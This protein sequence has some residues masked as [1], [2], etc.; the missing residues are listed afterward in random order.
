[1][2]LTPHNAAYQRLKESISQSYP[3][4]WFVAIAEDRIIAAS[5]NFRELKGLVQ[6]EGFDPRN[7]LIVEAGVSYPDF[8]DVFLD[9]LDR[10]DELHFAPSL[11]DKGR[12][13]H[14]RE[15]NCLQNPQQ[16]GLRFWREEM[17]EHGADDA[18]DLKSRSF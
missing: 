15:D 10:T 1:M 18:V 8:I 16:R 5:A 17:A 4:G 13:G 9:I 2:E 14:R 3:H 7:V 6:A 12:V 11:A